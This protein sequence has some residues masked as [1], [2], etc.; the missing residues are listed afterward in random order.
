LGWG[1]KIPGSEPGQALIY[2]ASEVCSGQVWSRPIF[3]TFLAGSLPIF[4]SENSLGFFSSVPRSYHIRAKSTIGDESV[5]QS[6]DL[7]RFPLTTEEAWTG[8][9][10]K[11]R[12]ASLSAKG[13]EEV[14]LQSTSIPS[15]V[16]DLQN[17]LDE[18]RTKRHEK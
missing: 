13:S 9:P 8:R 15:P 7:V 3:E 11:K 1:Q 6:R 12:D 18:V 17:K 16:E 14:F 2:C 10:E 4:S 5:R